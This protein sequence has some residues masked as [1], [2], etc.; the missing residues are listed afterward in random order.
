MVLFTENRDD[1]FYVL[2]SSEAGYGPKLSFKYAETDTVFT[3]YSKI[4]LYDTFITNKIPETETLNA[5]KIS[6]IC[7]SKM[8]MKFEMKDYFI[9]ATDDINSE[10]DFNR[11]TINKA[12]LILT[13][14]GEMYFDDNISLK[15][16]L[17][18][19]DDPQ[20]PFVYD[21]DYEYVPNTVV[22]TD[23][24]DVGEFTLNVTKVVQALVS[25]E[26]EN[27]GI[28]VRSERENKNFENIEFTAPDPNGSDIGPR[29]RIIYTP[30][31]LEE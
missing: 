12:E 3:E 17:M 27:F 16:Y 10:E 29:L 30:P 5:L 20:I 1:S 28:M 14:T 9:A 7:P 8:F 26:Y 4:A 22:S 31:Y 15:P 6:N 18:I 19:S 23:S 11:M 24:L 13:Q 25:S 21:E 2:N